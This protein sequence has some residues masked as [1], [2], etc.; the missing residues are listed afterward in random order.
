MHP[1]WFAIVIIFYFLSSYWLWKLINIFQYYD[2][3][4]ITHLSAS[5]LVNRKITEFYITKTTI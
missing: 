5:W 2:Y 3:G 1:L 4:T